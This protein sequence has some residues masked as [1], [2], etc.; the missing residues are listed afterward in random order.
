MTKFRVAT[1]FIVV[2]A[3]CFGLAPRAQADTLFTYSFTDDNSATAGYG[4]L[5][6]ELLAANL[7]G[8]ESGG[9]TVSGGAAAGVYTLYGN[10]N[11]DFSN[12]YSPSGAFVFNDL[13]YYPNDPLLDSYG[14][15]FTD[16]NGREINIWG[17]GTGVLYTFYRWSGG[18]YDVEAD[19]SIQF[20]AAVPEP[21]TLTLMGLG[22]V[23]LAGAVRRRRT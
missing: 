8:V 19:Q 14:L 3:A 22:L 2:I 1:V 4:T 7:Y 13:F 16:R 12:A 9:L 6:A 15:L 21:A 18:T 20:S 11:V 5:D 17:N 10:P 23:G